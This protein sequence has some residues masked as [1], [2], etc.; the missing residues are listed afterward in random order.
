MVLPLTLSVREIQSR[1]TSVRYTPVSAPR[2]RTGESVSQ[3]IARHEEQ[4]GFTGG[5]T[6]NLCVFKNQYVNPLVDV[7]LYAL[8]PE[9]VVTVTMYA[10]G[11]PVGTGV[12]A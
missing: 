11:A 4:R 9:G 2:T 1:E 3:Q 8:V 7:E 6:R 10:F 12:Q 5:M